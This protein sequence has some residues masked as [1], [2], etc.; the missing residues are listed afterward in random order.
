M[1][2]IAIPSLPPLDTIYT[3]Q[4]REKIREYFFQGPQFADTARGYWAFRFDRLWAKHRVA[5]GK[6]LGLVRSIGRWMPPEGRRV[7]VLGS[8]LGDEA[9]AYAMCG[10]RVVAI[11]LDEAA[12]RLAREL[13]VKYGV[14]LNTCRMDASRLALPADHFDLVSC[15]QVLEHVP[16]ER[17]AALVGEM[18]RVCKPGGLLWLDTPNQHNYKDKH[19]TGLP[20][21]H[22]LPRGM[23]TRL[24]ALLRRDV[25]TREP[26]FG[27]QAV[28]L[29]FYISYFGLLRM[30]GHLGRY[31][32]LSRYRGYADADHYLDA[33]RW[34]GRADGAL[35]PVK[36][37][38][39]R[40]LL[41]FW[42]FNWLS[43]IR[44]VVRKGSM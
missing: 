44:V 2:A 15:S 24:A 32:V 1:S 34:E 9:I 13:A 38:V 41:R 5:V 40:L 29:H 8:F 10:A 16:R 12:L 27:S 36:M 43:H 35:F 26:A 17:Q 3:D 19:D 42:G 6:S 37:A 31:A 39:L 21:I 11:D 22:W 28:G 14:S 33:R 23:K 18:W 4:W 20:L 30:L 25:P 7:L